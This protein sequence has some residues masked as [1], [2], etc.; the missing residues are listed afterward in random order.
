VE[1]VFRFF[2]SLAGQV[3]TS[4]PDIPFGFVSVKPS[5]AR[6]AILD[7]ICRFNSLVREEIE[8][9]PSGFYV[10]VFSAMR[11][12]AGQPQTELFL[13]DGLHLSRE[14]Y[15]LWG[16]ALQPYRQQILTG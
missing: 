9:R 12:G 6:R 3:A 4:L 15:R 5:P 14:G 11:N 2:R 10:D 7:R 16:R 8:S 13:E 1:C